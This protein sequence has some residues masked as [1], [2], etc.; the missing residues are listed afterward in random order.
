MMNHICDGELERGQCSDSRK[1]SLKKAGTKVGGGHGYIESTFFLSF[2]LTRNEKKKNVTHLFLFSQLRVALFQYSG[3][4]NCSE[5]RFEVMVTN[6]PELGNEIEM[7]LS[8]FF[9]SK[10]YY[11]QQRFGRS[12]VR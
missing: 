11:H 7:I 8:F 2:S 4:L 6:K 1:K 5:D 3:I 10:T 9:I 12:V